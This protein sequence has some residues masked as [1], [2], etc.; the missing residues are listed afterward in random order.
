MS[1]LLIMFV[2]RNQLKINLLEQTSLCSHESE[3]LSKRRI[4]DAEYSARNKKVF[5]LHLIITIKSTYNLHIRSPGSR[6][7]SGPVWRTL[8]QF[9][10]PLRRACTFGTLS[11]T[12]L[13]WAI[14][15]LLQWGLF[16]GLMILSVD[17][18]QIN[19]PYWS[20]FDKW[21]PLLR[22]MRDTRG[23]LYY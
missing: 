23:W 9:F 17:V 20:L 21:R 6:S 8:G 5:H 16:W 15:V 19:W 3:F 10:D 22:V 11:C 18:S 7:P 13:I 1:L 14:T 12:S 4:A 2:Q